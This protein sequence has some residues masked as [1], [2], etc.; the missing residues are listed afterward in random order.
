MALM[1][2]DLRQEMAPREEEDVNKLYT[3]WDLDPLWICRAIEAMLFKLTWTRSAKRCFD[4]ANNE[5]ALL[6]DAEVIVEFGTV[7]LGT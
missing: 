6:D 3:S 1:T 4:S 5:R 7:G 2:A